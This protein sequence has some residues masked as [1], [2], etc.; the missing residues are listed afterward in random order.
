VQVYNWIINAPAI[1]VVPATLPNG[2]TGMSYAAT[3]S[4]TGGAAPYSFS[5]T[6]GSL[7]IGVSFNS[8]GQFTGTPTSSGTFS[9]TI[10]ATD[11]NGF[12]GSQVYTWAINTGTVIVS[13]ETLAAGTVAV[14]Y[15]QTVTASAGIAPYTYVVT[16]GSLPTGI[17][18]NAA[19]GVLSG[20]PTG[21]G[22]C[23]LHNYSHR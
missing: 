16:A 4:A 21:T 5:L 14:P 20:T 10:T 22:Q 17:T 9:T 15:L 1:V 18:L 2:A 19:T 23:E 6:A 3:V 8:A 13:P 7:P 12:T 11:A